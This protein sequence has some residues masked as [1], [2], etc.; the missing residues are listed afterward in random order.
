[1]DATADTPRPAEF[2]VAV[3]GG[4]LSGASTA[5]LLKRADPSLRV[6]IIERDTAFKRRVGEATVEVSGFFLTRILGLTRFL[7]ETQLCKNGLR[8]W[9]ANADATDLSRCSE[10]GGRHLSMIPSFLVDRAVMDEEVL[11]RAV[12]AGVE[13]WRPA[14]VKSIGLESGGMQSLAVQSGGRTRGVRARWVVDASGVACLL[15]RANGWWR[16]NEAHPTLSVWSRWRGAGDWDSL[17]LAEKYPGWSKAYYGIRGTAT[18][19]YMGDGWWAWSIA[20]KGGD[21]S[22]G[23]VLDQRLRSLP[24]AGGKMGDRLRA[25]LSEHPAAREMMRDAE[26][27][28]GDV[29]FRRNLPYFSTTFAGD[30]FCLVGDAAGFIDPFYSPGMDWISYTVTAAKRN[31]LAWRKNEDLPDAIAATNRDFSLSYKR[32]FESLYRDKYDYLGDFEIMRLAFRLDIA[33]YY[34]FVAR[35]A[36]KLGPGEA[37]LEPTFSG[38]E[39]A[40]FAWMIGFYN[41]RFSAMARKRRELGTFGRMNAGERDLVP[42]FN[43]R[44]GVL[45]KIIIRALMG[46]L[47]L[48]LSEGWRSW[49]S[50][51]PTDHPKREAT[52]AGDHPTTSQAA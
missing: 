30:G 19:H 51:R 4:A 26:F 41:R 23:F 3:I 33:T 45:L 38:P 10:I 20:L 52:S 2:D 32:W 34:L 11:R 8:F 36:Y 6:L 14:T 28:E 40:P 42:G 17:E 12:E 37:L 47:W 49:G 46:W 7:T 1:M 39:A 9:F 5:L 21:T 22:I 43:F 27:I 25:F 44:I 48:E 15:A 50:L 29:H 24:A 16:P 18:N 13:L 31:I 35:W